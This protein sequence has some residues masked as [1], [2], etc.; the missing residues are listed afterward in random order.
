[1]NKSLTSTLLKD[2]KLYWHQ[3]LLPMPGVLLTNKAY[4][5]QFCH[6]TIPCAYKYVK[7]LYGQVLVFMVSHSDD[8][9]YLSIHYAVATNKADQLP[10]YC[11]QFALISLSTKDIADRFEVYN[12][13][14][15]I[16]N[17]FAPAH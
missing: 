15:N 8:R 9:V 1:M 7:W 16:Y 10:L 13:V 3:D 4:I 14:C 17:K 6:Y 5:L 12:L 2:P 11:Y